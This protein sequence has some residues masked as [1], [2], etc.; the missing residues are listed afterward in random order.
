MKLGIKLIMISLGVVC[1]FQT[2]QAQIQQGSFG[3]YNDALRY[4]Q[5]QNFGTARF[6]ALAGS[7]SVLGGDI[8]SAI[9]NPAGL[10]V[11]NRSQFTFTPG[12][13]SLQTEGDSFGSTNKDEA[14][15]FSIANLG[16]VINFNKGDLI[17]GSFRGGSLAITYN[18]INDFNRNVLSSGYNG[19]NSIID[20]MLQQADG[21]FPDELNGIAQTGY[22]HYIINPDPNDQTLYHSPVLGFPTQTETIRTKG[23]TDQVNIAYGTNFDDK[24]YLG[25]GMGI[26]SSN[27][28]NSRIYTESFNN[29]PLSSFTIDERLELNGTGVNFNIGAIVRPVDVLRVGLS[30]TSP[31]F[32]SFNEE[33]DNVY[34]SEWNNYDVSNFRDDQNNRLI[35][36]DT[37]LNTLQ[38]ATDIFVSTFNLRTPAK[39]NAGLAFFF[40]KNGFITADIEH[41]NYANANVS[42]SDFFSG[43]DNT[44][45]ENIYNSVTNIKLG[46]EYRYEMF[47]FRVGYANYGD[48][49]KSNFDGV[50]LDRSKKIVSGGLG[51]N[52]G[53]YFF[54][55]ALVNTKYDESFRSYRMAVL[56]DSP[57]TTIKHNF[58]NAKLTFGLNF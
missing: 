39:L 44:T 49:Y 45:I 22:D 8:S 4:S 57:L 54:D 20:N 34:T 3:Y 14:N 38:T 1:L 50:D 13:S 11:F 19:D 53:K 32:Y 27:Y 42:S 10:G 52:M 26:T 30:Y 48:P 58:T 43:N 18:R 24:I 25:A 31:T 9:Y 17:P 5:L 40:N 35:L 51:I 47:R 36:E 2:S 28:S 23:Y 41:L 12:F 46:G 6:S 37:V 15:K 21:F 56:E 7:G 33:G 16:V 55:F 29:E